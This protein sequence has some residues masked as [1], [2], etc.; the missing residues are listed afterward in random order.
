MF[1]FLQKNHHSNFPPKFS[2]YCSEIGFLRAAVRKECAVPGNRVLHLPV[3]LAGPD[4]RGA[5]QFVPLIVWESGANAWRETQTDPQNPEPRRRKVFPA[6]HRSLFP[7]VVPSLQITIG[8]RCLTAA[9]VV[10]AISQHQR[11][12]SAG[13]A[14]HKGDHCVSASQP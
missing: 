10:L 8:R 13:A 7:V 9:S 6:M 1:Y 5:G 3:L 2:W 11:F 4:W 14:A 12:C